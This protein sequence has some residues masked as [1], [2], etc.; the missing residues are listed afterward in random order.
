MRWKQRAHEDW[1]QHGEKNS[2]LF[3]ACVNQKRRNNQIV[4]IID[5]AGVQCMHPDSVEEAFVNYFCGVLTTSQPTGL[6][7]ALG[8]LS[9][10]IS[11]EE[12]HNLVKGVTMEEVST[13]LNQMTP[14]KAPGPYGFPAGFYQENWAAVGNEVFLAIKIFFLSRVAFVLLLIPL[15]LLLLLKRLTL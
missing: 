13:A 9:C 4:I 6:D 7:E 12:N 1:L 5:E 2:K 14:L 8:V 10:R 11:E 15:L 3:H